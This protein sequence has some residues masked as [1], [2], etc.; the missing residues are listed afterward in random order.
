MSGRLFIT[1]DTHGT[2]D[3]DKV[4]KFSKRPDLTSDDVLIICGD[5]GLVWSES[6]SEMEWRRWYSEQPFTTLFIAGNHEN[7]NLLN[8][9][10]HYDWNG[11]TVRYVCNKVYHLMNGVYTINNKKIL[12]IGGA[13][14]H[15]K[16]YRVKKVD[17]WEQELPSATQLGNIQN[18]INQTDKQFDVIITHCAPDWV[19]DFWHYNNY[20]KNRLTHFLDHVSE[21]VQ[22][23]EWYCGH[24][25]KDD[26]V[27]INDTT[28]FRL[29]YDDVIQII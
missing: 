17:W 2:I 5:F 14:S 7:Y 9:L 6:Q 20:P 3:I 26:S 19:Q 29:L 25:H 18:A 15:D 8:K 4:I 21:T 1:G 12:V 13:E 23:S 11:I 16:E 28:K 27:I 24:Y 22:Y 10:P